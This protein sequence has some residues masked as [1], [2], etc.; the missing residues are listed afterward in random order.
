[1]RLLFFGTPQF[2]RVALEKL[3]SSRHQVAGV[4]TA[5]DKPQGRGRK[6]KSPEVKKL[7]LERG[8]EVLQPVK[9][10]DAD[11]LERVRQIGADLFAVVAFR[12]L[13]EKLYTIPPWGA[14]NL[15]ASKLPR[16]RGA[17]PIERALMAGATET[18]VTTFQIASKVDTGAVLMSKSVEIL[19]DDT[20]EDLSPRLAAVG[21]DL[22]VETIDRL[23]LGE[24]KPQP[25]DDSLA[26]PAPKITLEDSPIDWERPAREI[27]N[28]IRGL[29]GS[30]DAYT[31][32]GEKRLKVL[33]ARVA[34]VANGSYPPGEVIT[35]D[36]KRGLTV[37]TAAGAV[38]LEEVCLEGKKRMPVAAFLNGVRVEPGTRLTAS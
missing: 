30:A 3:L 18:G 19:P 34:P 37:A 36:A 1:M 32:L 10:K 13:P 35:A 33:R 14:I 2:A 25:Q 38:A 28:Q 21:G 17:A 31:W 16:W 6:M 27:V 11:F 20:Y 9:L 7:A 15:H 22:L 23:E 29:A 26:S 4:V 12:I 24:L 5:P 8:L